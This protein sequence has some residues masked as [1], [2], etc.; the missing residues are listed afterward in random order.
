MRWA[1]R[2]SRE[3]VG[4][5]DQQLW[6][7]VIGTDDKTDQERTFT[8]YT[9]SGSFLVVDDKGNERLAGPDSG[10]NKYDILR[11][12]MV[13]FQVHGLRVKSSSEARPSIA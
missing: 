8:V 13:Q 5:D 4:S 2:S 11:E 12:V 7:E 10:L 9:R 1:K 6:G 3:E